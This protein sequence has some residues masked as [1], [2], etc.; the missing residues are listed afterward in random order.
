PG[1]PGPATVTATVTPTPPGGT[2]K[3]FSGQFEI[4]ESAVD[5]STGVA[6]IPVT[7]LTAGTHD[8]GVTF[9]GVGTYSPS[10]TVVTHTLLPAPTVD[11]SVPGAVTIGLDANAT[12]TAHVNINDPSGTVTFYRG[13]LV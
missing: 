5:A 12:F 4:G 6:T 3:V 7:G 13:N 11:L 8:Y 9:F 10:S 1:F 2:V